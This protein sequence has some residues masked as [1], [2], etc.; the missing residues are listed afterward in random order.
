MVRRWHRRERKQTGV[1]MWATFS[2]VSSHTH[3]LLG[4][5]TSNVLLSGTVC[6]PG[7]RVQLPKQPN[8]ISRPQNSCR[9]TTTPA[10]GAAL[11]LKHTHERLLKEE[12]PLCSVTSRLQTFIFRA[13][14]DH[15]RPFNLVTLSI[16]PNFSSFHKPVQFCASCFYPVFSFA[17]GV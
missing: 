6:P 8:F 1:P 12:L 2:P 9:E 16:L 4:E 5:G 13:S 15:S 17:G 14:E 11:L 7:V 3:V 10:G